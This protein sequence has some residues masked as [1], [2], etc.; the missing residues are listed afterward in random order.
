MKW[1]EKF[2]DF[3]GDKSEVEMSIDEKTDSTKIE[4]NSK[5]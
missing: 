3:E 2:E 4:N 5:S 1:V